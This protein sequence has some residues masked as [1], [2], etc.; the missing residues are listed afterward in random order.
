MRPLALRYDIN[1]LNGVHFKKGS[2]AAAPCMY[3]GTKI[4]YKIDK[5]DF[6]GSMSMVVHRTDLT[7][8]SGPPLQ[9]SLSNAALEHINKY[10]VNDIL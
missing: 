8:K 2:Y 3:T 7:L 6:E 9:E 5:F 10:T 1:R 4:W